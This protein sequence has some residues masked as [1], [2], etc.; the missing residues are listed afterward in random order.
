[1]PPGSLLRWALVVAVLPACLRVACGEMPARDRGAGTAASCPRKPSGQEDMHSKTRGWPSKGV[2]LLQKVTVAHAG[3]E[4]AES[5]SK[6]DPSPAA[7]AVMGHRAVAG[8]T[9]VAAVPPFTAPS[10]SAPKAA[11]GA[12]SKV[13][14]SEGQPSSVAAAP[15]NSRGSRRR[16]LSLQEL[17]RGLLVAGRSLPGTLPE[18]SQN[19]FIV[20]I[21][22]CTLAVVVLMCCCFKDC[23]CRPGIQMRWWL[24]R[25]G[26]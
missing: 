7:A 16:L 2:S 12:A 1:M 17:A 18:S 23:W 10:D 20:I 26:L 19:I 14:A 6:A 8:S 24:M 13:A 9:L 15:P 21:V 22:A 5:T 11:P 4:V 25:S 3:V